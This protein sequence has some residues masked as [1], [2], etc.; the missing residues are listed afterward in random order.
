MDPLS[1]LSLSGTLVHPN[2]EPWDNV[3]KNGKDYWTAEVVD[4]HLMKFHD[5]FLTEDKSNLDILVPMSG[6]TQA[7][8]LLSA[9]GHRV[10]GIEWSRC[11]VEMFFEENGLEHSSQQVTVSSTDMTMYVADR[12]AITIYCGNFFAFKG[13]NLG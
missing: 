4:V 7:M 13:E 12:K 6:K 11:A 1:N 5:T 10:V 8:L 9:K 2:R 3:Y